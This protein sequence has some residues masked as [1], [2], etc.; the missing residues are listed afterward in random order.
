MGEKLV[1]LI[2]KYKDSGF[3]PSSPREFVK[4]AYSRDESG[5]GG[6]GEEKLF[7]QREKTPLFSASVCVRPVLG[8]SEEGEKEKW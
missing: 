6:G 8:D 5:E 7:F 1:L 3:P 4:R 2:R